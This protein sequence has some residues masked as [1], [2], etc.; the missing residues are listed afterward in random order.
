[1]YR[2]V[3]CKMS[4]DIV[5]NLSSFKYIPT[6]FLTYILKIIVTFFKIGNFNVSFIIQSKSQE[7]KARTT[8]KL[9]F[10]N[11]IHSKLEKLNIFQ[12]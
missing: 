6:I 4:K 10:E 5:M 12:L 9:V 11:V 2:Y 3:K 7:K 8:L 1:M